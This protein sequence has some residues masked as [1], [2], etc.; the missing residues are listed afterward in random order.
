MRGELRI[1]LFIG[2][3]GYL[4]YNICLLL[5]F[6]IAEAIKVQNSQHALYLAGQTQIHI[7]LAFATHALNEVFLK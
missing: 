2:A 6:P 4:I 5:T 1:S 7:T 3:E